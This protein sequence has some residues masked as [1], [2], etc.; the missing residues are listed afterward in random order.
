MSKLLS[1]V[2]V[3]IDSTVTVHPPVDPGN[4]DRYR[5]CVFVNDS[6]GFI[7]IQFAGT[8]DDLRLFAN[9]LTTAID[10]IDTAIK[11]HTNV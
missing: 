4:P 8:I 10:H 3:N 9:N 11:E 7:G 5:T 1:M 6:N 2:S